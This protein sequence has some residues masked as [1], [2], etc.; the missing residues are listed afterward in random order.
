MNVLPHNVSTAHHKS[1]P[2]NLEEG[3]LVF[4]PSR[5]QL[6]IVEIRYYLGAAELAT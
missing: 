4:Q 1:V 2:E 6:V 5:W 3:G